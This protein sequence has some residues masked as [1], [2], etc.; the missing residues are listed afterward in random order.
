MRP[1]ELKCLLEDTLALIEDMMPGVAYIA[2]QD[3]AP[4]NEVPLRLRV[5]L[6]NLER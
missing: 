2:L 4:L 1:S 5:A 3:Y 6:R